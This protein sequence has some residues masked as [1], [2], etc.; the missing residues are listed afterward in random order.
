VAPAL[1]LVELQTGRAEAERAEG[2]S[3]GE[4]AK[5]LSLFDEA[6]AL[7]EAA[8]AHSE[9]TAAYRAAI[10]A[11]PRETEQLR[12]RLAELGRESPASEGLGVSA[13]TPAA[14]IEQRL[15]EE[16]GALAALEST[17]AALDEQVRAQVDRPVQARA[18][19]ARVRGALTELRD[20]RPT[21]TPPTE[22]PV[23]TRASL[24]VADARVQA[25]AAE[26]A[27]IEQELLSHGARLDL[28]EVRRD[29]AARELAGARTRL[30]LLQ[31]L[32]ID[33]RRRETTG[34]VERAAEAV[35]EASA[36]HPVVR[37]AAEENAALTRRRADLASRL[38]VVAREVSATEERTRRLEQ[39]FRRARQRVELA[40]VSSAVARQLMQERRGLPAI[41][42]DRG[43]LLKRYAREPA[44]S[45][46]DEAA[47]V[48]L[49]ALDVEERRRALADLQEAADDRME[50]VEPTMPG[51]EREAL[52]ADLLTLMEERQ[53]LLGKVDTALSAYL[54]ALGDLDFAQARLEGVGKAYADYLAGRLLWIPSTYPVSEG[55]LANLRAAIAWQIE[56]EHWGGV[57]VAL[58]SDLQRHPLLWSLSALAVILLALSAPRVLRRLKAIAARVQDSATDRF[59]LTVTAVLLTALLVLPLPLALAALGWRL[60]VGVEATEFSQRLGA[61][62]A[63]VARG[64]YAVLLLLA[65]VR[66]WGVA[67]AHFRWSKPALQRLQSQLRILLVLGIPAALVAASVGQFADETYSASLGRT[68]FVVLMVVIA[69]VLAR[70]LSPRGPVIRPHLTATP[71]RRFAQLWILWYPAVVGAPLALGGLAAWGYYYTAGQLALPA[72]QTLLLVFGAVAVYSLGLRWLEVG[73]REMTFKLARENVEAQAARRAGPED[74]RGP[75]PIASASADLAAIEAQTRQLFN[76]VLLLGGPLALWAVWSHVL[77]AFDLFQGLT[78]WSYTD[79]VG[80]QSVTVPITL[81]SVL[82]AVVIGVVA[83]AMARSLPAVL[84][85]V[86]LRHLSLARGSRYAIK[87]LLQYAI[88]TLG[89]LFAFGTLGLSWSKV[90]WLVAALSVG[91]GFGLQEIVANFISGII[92]LFERPIRVGDWVTVGNLTGTVSNISIRATTITDFDRKEI[93]V[94]NKALITTEVVNWSLSDPITRI[95]VLVGIAYGSKVEKARQ[96]ML[97]TLRSLPLVRSDPEPRVWFVGFGASSLDFEV[98][99]F[100]S[101]LSDRMPLTNAVHVALEQALREHGIEI[102]FP[103][104][105]LHLRTVSPEAGAALRG[106]DGTPPPG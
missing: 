78:L 17:L 23:L 3:A 92:I 10:E 11:A 75:S 95:K 53:A 99:V 14:E 50:Q 55:S 29:L 30:R 6:K 73:R 37:A 9:A 20:A 43:R 39:D 66:P 32:L 65:L 64:L 42:T 74:V 96:V 89:V 51:R 76:M 33:A 28:L 44:V 8:R 31:S 87:T 5:A 19:L 90:Q 41:V 49:E 36:K 24:A 79:T 38:E 60:E 91:L 84:E 56:A 1:G 69:Y 15:A 54:T 4:K 45:R 35:R 82:L 97:D 105:D 63:V 47:A 22:P 106:G 77:P 34:A 7:L 104:Q 18:E 81:R 59:S 83:G 88:A 98:H 62:L 2:L 58:A 40:G 93:L 26:L 86:L 101:E 72:T 57:R 46:Q 25:K 100:A 52:R 61:G 102:A 85:V 21:P 80:G 70:I 13:T 67:G 27:R 12:Q 71:P 68:A 48:A 103:Q 16:K 94:P